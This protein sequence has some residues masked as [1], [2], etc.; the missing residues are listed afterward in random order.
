MS[1]NMDRYAAFTRELA[2]FTA[3]TLQ[4]DL[5]LPDERAHELGLK[6]A[7]GVSDE[8]A[9]EIIY[10]GKNTLAKVDQRDRDM[11]AVFV[12]NGR[13][14]LPVVKQFGVC[15]QTAYKRVR[16]AEAAENALRQGALFAGPDAD[17]DAA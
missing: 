2:D 15:M 17:P 9:G 6:I 12:A 5:E 1:T 13:D 8:F 16:I 10:V 4:E 7:L 14:I 11:L 3:R